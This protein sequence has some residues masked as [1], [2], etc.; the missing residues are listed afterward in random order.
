MKK[1]LRQLKCT[2][3]FFLWLLLA[4]FVCDVVVTV[5]SVLVLLVTGLASFKLTLL[6]CLACAVPFILIWLLVGR[7]T[8]SA[9]KPNRIG[10]VIVLALWVGVPALC[11]EVFDLVLLPQLLCGD[12]PERLLE[13]AL[14]NLGYDEGRILI[15]GCVLM[16]LLIGVGLALPRKEAA[17]TAPSGETDF[18]D[19]NGCPQA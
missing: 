19:G 13:L 3:L 10:A 17:D 2:A 7:Q 11:P 12:L 6:E 9:A 1:F 15:L 18:P 16:A 8:P 5:A 14:P 4:Q